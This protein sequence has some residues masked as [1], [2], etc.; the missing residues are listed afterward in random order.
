MQNIYW[1]SELSR[2]SLPVAGGKGANL[3]EMANAN[4]PIPPGFVVSSESYLAFVKKAGIDKTIL[5][6]T[7]SLDTQ[8]TR[9]LNSASEKIKR[10][11]VASEM[12]PDLAAEIVRAYNKLCGADLIPTHEQEVYVAVRSSATAEDLPEASFA[13]SLPLGSFLWGLPRVLQPAL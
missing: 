8:D 7:G 3:G 2:K 1:F 9:S 4:L 11:I 5:Q 12:P 6:E 10:A 13:P